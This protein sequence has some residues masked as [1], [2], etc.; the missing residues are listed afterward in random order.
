[1]TVGMRSRPPSS[2]SAYFGISGSGMVSINRWT[3][4]SVAM[5]SAWAWKL[6]LIR[7]RSTGMAI[8]RTSSMATEKRPS[9]AASALPPLIKN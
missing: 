6:V 3:T 4:S 2:T 1:M 7:C 8:F 9:M 5:P